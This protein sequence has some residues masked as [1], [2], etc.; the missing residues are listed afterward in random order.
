MAVAPVDLTRQHEPFRA[1]F[2]A[3]FD[4]IVGSGLF[5]R[6][7]DIEAFEAQ[8]TRYC[9]TRHAAAVSSGTDALLAALMAIGVGPGDEVI[10]PTFTFFATAGSVARAGASPVFVDVD[11]QTLNL[12]V[13][14]AAQAITARTKAIMPVH[15]FGR[16]AD[17]PAIQQL[18]ADRDLKVIEDAAQAIG[19]RDANGRLGGAIGDVGCFSFFPTKNLSAMGDA[20]AC[21]TNDAAL[22]ECLRQL[23]NHGQ[24]GEYEHALIG[25][26]FRMDCL[27]AAV[28]SIKLPHVDRWTQVRRALAGKYSQ[29]LSDLPIRLPDPGPAGA[30]VWHQ[31]TIRLADR[32]QRDALLQHLRSRKIFA[33]VFYPRP[34]HLQPCF[35]PLGGEVGDCPVAEQAA[36]C[37]LSLPIY[38]ELTDQQ[39]QEVVLAIRAFF[40]A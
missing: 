17:M 10:V 21:V 7:P 6:G 38:P 15:L 18:A 28:L 16:L 25:G 24:S 34:L 31:Y 35:A 19:A 40:H 37:V 30:H 27:Q 12:D 23:R 11:E 13:S 1:E 39:Q 33:G 3:A 9:G 4:R 32:A 14:L 20:G 5:V 22:A 8:L 26:N 29:R 2:R 36:Q